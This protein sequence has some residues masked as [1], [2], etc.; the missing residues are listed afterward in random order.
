MAVGLRWL[1]MGLGGFLSDLDSGRG[2]RGVAVDG[3][4]EW[5]PIAGPPLRQQRQRGHRPLHHRPEPQLSRIRPLLLVGTPFPSIS[6]SLSLQVVP[7]FTGPYR[8]Y[9]AETFAPQQ[10][11]TSWP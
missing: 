5:Q 4:V 9:L 1:V 6:L 2:R 10:V 7:S 8:V 11:S 3:R